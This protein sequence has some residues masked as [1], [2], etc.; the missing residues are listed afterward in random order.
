MKQKQEQVA[1]KDRWQPRR[2]VWLIGLRRADLNGAKGIIQGDGNG[3]VVVQLDHVKGG[4]TVAITHDHLSS[5]PPDNGSQEQA[6]GPQTRAPGVQTHDRALATPLAT[7]PRIKAVVLVLA[8]CAAVAVVG[9]AGHHEEGSVV[10][11]Q[12][13]RQ[14]EFSECEAVVVGHEGF[15]VQLR[16]TQGPHHTLG[17]EIRVKRTNVAQVEKPT[18]NM[19]PTTHPIHPSTA[20]S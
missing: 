12:G 13:L 1:A 16:L 20:P 10:C 19:A 7:P 8:A 9:S 17:R 3:R 11:L 14:M 15:R 2:K 4:K 18:T 6:S 5:L